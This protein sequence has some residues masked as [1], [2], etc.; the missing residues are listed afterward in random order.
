MSRGQGH[1]KI[2]DTTKIEFFVYQNQI[3]IASKVALH[4][5]RVEGIEVPILRGICDCLLRVKNQT[6]TTV[7]NKETAIRGGRRFLSHIVTCA[8]TPLIEGVV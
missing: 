8:N 4:Y 6:E 3:E 7:P 1:Y 2:Y 5:S